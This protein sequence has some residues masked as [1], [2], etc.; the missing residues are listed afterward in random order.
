MTKEQKHNIVEFMKTPHYEGFLKAI[1][2]EIPNINN[3]FWREDGCINA[4]VET[5]TND[6]F[7]EEEFEY[8]LVTCDL[9]NNY[10]LRIV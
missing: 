6:E 3:I 10:K 9:E 8:H 4:V 1:E 2:A 5:V 7:V